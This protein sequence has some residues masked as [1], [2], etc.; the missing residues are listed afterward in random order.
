MKPGANYYNAKVNFEV[1]SGRTYQI[2]VDGHSYWGAGEI[3]LLL[4]YY[5]PPVILA[6]T[7]AKANGFSFK[8]QGQPGKS[9]YVAVSTNLEDWVV[10]GTN[11]YSGSLFECDVPTPGD[12]QSVSFYRLIEK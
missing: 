3:H 6:N 11:R 2:G 4:H 10:S 9:Y 12:S 5:I 1:K 7:F 8:A